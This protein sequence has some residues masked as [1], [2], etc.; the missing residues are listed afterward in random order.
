MKRGADD[1]RHPSALPLRFF[2]AAETT[3]REQTT[4]CRQMDM[5]VNLAA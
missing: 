2:A 1:S 3:H 4:R 5:H